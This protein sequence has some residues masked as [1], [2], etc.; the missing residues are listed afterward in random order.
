MNYLEV[1]NAAKSLSDEERGKLVRAIWPRFDADFNLKTAIAISFREREP[2][3]VPGHES[4][5]VD[6]ENVTDLYV[7]LISITVDTGD[8]LTTGAFPDYY[9]LAPG[10]RCG[11]GLRM[12]NGHNDVMRIIVH[13]HAMVFG[14]IVNKSIVGYKLSLF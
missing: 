1:L 12:P 9:T 10:E 5:V 8:E 3:I 14:G 2:S 7:Q 4:I 13:G 11:H 6:L